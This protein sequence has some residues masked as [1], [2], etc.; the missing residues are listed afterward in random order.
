MALQLCAG[1]FG[2]WPDSSGRGAAGRQADDDCGIAW[3]MVTVG[4][5]EW[6]AFQCKN[7]H[8][9]HEFG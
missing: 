6:Q 3:L 2:A 5:I 7:E 8:V 4:Y 1:S 9:R